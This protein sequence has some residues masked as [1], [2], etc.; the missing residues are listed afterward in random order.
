MIRTILLLFFITLNQTLISQNVSIT[1][2]QEVKERLMKNKSNLDLAFQTVNTSTFIPVKIHIVGTDEGEDRANERDVLTML[3]NLNNNFLA[4]D[5][6][7]YLYEDFNYI[8]NTTLHEFNSTH[9]SNI[10]F[11]NNRVN[12]VINFYIVKDMGNPQLFLKYDPAEGRDWIVARRDKITDNPPIFMMKG[13]G[14]YLSLLP[15]YWCWNAFPQFD[16]TNDSIFCYNGNLEPIELQ[17]GSN[18]DVA[19]DLIC[20]TPPDYFFGNTWTNCNFTLEVAD[21]NGDI[22]NPMEDNVM[23]SFNNAN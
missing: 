18:C 21:P 23:S 2:F 17:N 19:G 4:V 6:Q 11:E 9:H 3:C 5:I 22:V 10:Q 14:S 16:S 13:L 15:T 1:D 12:N 7:F 20:D 8:D